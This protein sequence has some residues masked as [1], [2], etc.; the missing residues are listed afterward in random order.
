MADSSVPG[1]GNPDSSAGSTDDADDVLLGGAPAASVAGSGVSLE[2]A[3]RDAQRLREECKLYH[4]PATSDLDALLRHI[5]GSRA[6]VIACHQLRAEQWKARALAAE[7]ATS[8]TATSSD[9]RS[10]QTW[11]QKALT[12][13]IANT[14]RAVQAGQVSDTEDPLQMAWVRTATQLHAITMLAATWATEPYPATGDAGYNQG[15]D[16]CRETLVD[17][18]SAVLA[19]TE[20]PPG[21]E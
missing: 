19:L 21:Q 13:A 6:F 11:L 16:G 10:L 9:E 17:Q 15:W 20:P 1:A 7:S 14:E 4:L 2:Q 12:D 3:E 18:L 5:E 8:T